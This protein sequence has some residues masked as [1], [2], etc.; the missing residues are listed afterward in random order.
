MKRKRFKILSLAL[1]GALLLGTIFSTATFAVKAADGDILYWKSKV[2]GGIRLTAELSDRTAINEQTLDLDKDKKYE[3]LLHLDGSTLSDAVKFL[4]GIKLQVTVN[5]VPQ[6]LK[7]ESKDKEL[8]LKCDI[9]PEAKAGTNDI[10]IEINEHKTILGL[11]NP[12]KLRKIIKYRTMVTV[13]YY[14]DENS[15]VISKTEK[16]AY[17]DDLTYRP[18]DRTDQT[19]KGWVKKDA[20][21]SD[22]ITK[23]DDNISLVGKWENNKAAD[24]SN[25]QPNPNPGNQDPSNPNPGGQNP[26]PNQSNP[27]PG[28]PS[29]PGNDEYIPPV[30]IEP[31]PTTPDTVIADNNTLLSPAENNGGININ[32]EDTPLSAAATIEDED[33]EIADDDAPLAGD[34][35]D[36]ENEDTPLSDVPKTGESYLIKSIIVLAVSTIS[37]SIL[38]IFNRK[39]LNNR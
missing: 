27:D 33:I 7:D 14:D 26:N 36:I 17:G 30:F 39:K 16:L 1:S 35:I 21:D 10:I 11:I 37:L 4:N 12:V 5:N 28:V 2:Q 29:T 34:N 18:A 3:T 25:P 22:F 19:F 15:Q 32:D 9:E 20:P 23:A 13:N 8:I 31:V 6:T 38:T 24:P